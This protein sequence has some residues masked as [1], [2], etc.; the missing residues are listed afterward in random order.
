MRVA[1]ALATLFGVGRAPFAPGT[2]ASLAALP[3]AWLIAGHDERFLLPV[4]SIMATAIGVWACELYVRRAKDDDPKECVIDE[5]AGQW[6]ACSFAP[7]SLFAYAIAFLSFRLF[8][9]AKPWPVSAAEKLKGGLGVMADD[10]VAG[11]LAGLIVAGC[12]LAG[13]V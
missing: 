5:L 4:A 9:I 12:A 10:I 2:M 13:V 8:D 11:L 1:A 6:L 7:H 3:F